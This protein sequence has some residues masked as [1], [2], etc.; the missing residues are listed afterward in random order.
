MVDGAQA[1]HCAMAG[2]DHVGFGGRF[3]GMTAP[4][5]DAVTARRGFHQLV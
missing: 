1:L 2:T 4:T 3:S 5:D